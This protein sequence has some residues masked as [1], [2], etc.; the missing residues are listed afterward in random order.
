MDDGADLHRDLELE[1]I[2][3]LAAAL[4]LLPAA[5]REDEADEERED[6]E[7]PVA[8]HVRHAHDELRRLRELAVQVIEDPREDRD[9]EHEHEGEDEERER[10]DDARIDHR[11]LDPAPEFVLLLD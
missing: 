8:H 3:E 7:P 5:E 1:A 10:D 4:G 11:A 6:D 9:D 2:P